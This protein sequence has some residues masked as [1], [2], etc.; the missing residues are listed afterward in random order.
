MGNHP[1][2][3]GTSAAKAGVT[4]GLW[5]TRPEL[6]PFKIK[7]SFS[8]KTM[9]PGPLQSKATSLQSMATSSLQLQSELTYIPLYS[10]KGIQ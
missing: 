10:P 9:K 4:C 6:G 2:Q 5:T 7:A 8:A 3:Q 1:S